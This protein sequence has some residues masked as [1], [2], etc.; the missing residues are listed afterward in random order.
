MCLYF[1]VTPLPFWRSC[2]PRA[3]KLNGLSLGIPIG[4][5]PCR[6]LSYLS[7]LRQWSA[8]VVVQLNTCWMLVPPK[9]KSLG[10]LPSSMCRTCQ[11]IGVCV[12]GQWLLCW[13][14]WH[15]TSFWEVSSLSTKCRECVFPMYCKQDPWFAVEEESAEHTSIVNGYLGVFWQFW[16][17]PYSFWKPS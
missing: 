17:V 12:C 13:K 7:C 1:A 2:G 11:A 5:R 15:S 16:I 14:S 8:G 3:S 9:K 6:M 10:S 4:Y